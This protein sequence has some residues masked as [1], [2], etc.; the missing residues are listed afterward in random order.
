VFWVAFLKQ[1]LNPLQV[2][3]TAGIYRKFK[4]DLGRIRKRMIINVDDS[5]K[6]TN[7]KLIVLRLKLKS[8]QH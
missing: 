7:S 8:C 5:S 1:S 3:E 4:E 2:A 6:V